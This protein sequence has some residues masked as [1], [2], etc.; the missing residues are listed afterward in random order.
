M[1]NLGSIY[2]SLGDYAKAE[3]LMRKGIE[4]IE[5]RTPDESQLHFFRG[6]LARTLMLRGKLSEARDL[7]ARALKGLAAR[8]GPTSFGYALETYRLARIE[9]AAGNLDAAEQT[10]SKAMQV[11]EPLIPAQHTLRAQ[12]AVVRGMI[13]KARGDLET[14]QRELESA[15]AMQRKLND[16]DQVNLAVIRERLAGILLARG[17]IAAAKQK[18]GE[19]LPVLERELVGTSVELMEA[20]VYA[21]QL[22]SGD[23][24]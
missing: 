16:A 11:F 4:A 15:E 14:A 3:A 21:A 5:K 18:L 13:A 24:H 10:L 8:D 2:E 6:N 20:R 7:V 19:A 12:A 22:A 9:L 1:V 17:N 23:A